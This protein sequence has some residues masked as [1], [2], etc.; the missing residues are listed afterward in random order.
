MQEYTVGMYYW[1]MLDSL[2]RDREIL[3]ATD[4]NTGMQPAKY[5][6]NDEW[7]IVGHTYKFKACFVGREL[8]IPDGVCIYLKDLKIHFSDVGN[9]S[10]HR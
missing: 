4:V 1:I 8:V 9:V 5:C 7:Q 6:G 2:S 3:E 10:T